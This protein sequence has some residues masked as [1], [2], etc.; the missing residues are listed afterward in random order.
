[1]GNKFV[2]LRNPS[3][4][5]R[6]AVATRK[7]PND[8]TVYGKLPVD[9]SNALLFLDEINGKGA[10]KITA[11]HFVGKALALVLKKYP[12]LNG[13]IRWKRIYLRKKVDL[14]FHVA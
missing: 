12:D 8:P 10:Q 14:F 9:F 2:K 11:T 6:I 1:M 3:A 4:W 7:A 13:I 5:R